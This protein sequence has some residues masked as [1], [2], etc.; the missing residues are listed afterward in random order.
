MII[1]C[2]DCGKKL[3][4]PPAM[5]G[6]K[7]KCPA[8][9]AIIRIKKAREKKGHTKKLTHALIDKAVSENMEHPVLRILYRYETKFDAY[10]QNLYSLYEMIRKGTIHHRTFRIKKRDLKR[11][12]FTDFVAD[13]NRFPD[14]SLTPLDKI[15]LWQYIFRFFP[16]TYEGMPDGVYYNS[17]PRYDLANI[18]GMGYTTRPLKDKALAYQIIGLKVELLDLR[19]TIDSVLRKLTPLSEY[20]KFSDRVFQVIGTNE[21]LRAVAH[22]HWKKDVEQVYENFGF[23]FNWIA[24]HVE[25]CSDGMVPS[26]PVPV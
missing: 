20:C 21:E 19:K 1:Y 3:K 13:I 26:S 18:I 15:V 12:T 24:M 8:C 16:Y 5:K 9:G 10:S 25:E 14:Y 4:M 22:G 17:Y 6:T 23:G 7:G 2:G 11:E